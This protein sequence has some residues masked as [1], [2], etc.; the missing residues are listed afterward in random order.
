VGEYFEHLSDLALEVLRVQL[1]RFQKEPSDVRLQVLTLAGK[2][3]MN[4]SKGD[5]K[6]CGFAKQ[7]FIHALTLARFD[8]DWDIR[9]RGRLLEGLLSKEEGMGSTLK[10]LLSC[11]K[12]QSDPGNIDPF[13]APQVFQDDSIKLGSL[14]HVTGCKSSGRDFVTPWTS[15]PADPSVREEPNG[16]AY[17]AD[18][19]PSYTQSTLN[20]FGSPDASGEDRLYGVIRPT[21]RSV[22]EFY[23][24]SEESGDDSDG[25]Y[26]TDEID[27]GGE[28]NQ[29]N[30]GNHDKNGDSTSKGVEVD[31]DAVADT[32]E[33]PHAHATPKDPTAIDHPPALLDLL[34]PIPASGVLPA[35][36]PE[37][38]VQHGGFD[39]HSA[40][41]AFLEAG[42]QGR[43]E[44]SNEISQKI[45]AL[46]DNLRKPSVTHYV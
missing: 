12:P 33:M 15:A 36:F 2:C 5:S 44:P 32:T 31:G 7:A 3:A 25:S 39:S 43:T 21:P 37:A 29:E 42:E 41:D 35:A 19:M 28:E 18:T 26:S 23:S 22:A 30:Q 14:L 1:A 11:R 45:D 46:L 9:G 17:S 13:V 8:S 38:G 34:D 40:I 10:T 6:L 24:E 27:D 20:G 16:V 4:C